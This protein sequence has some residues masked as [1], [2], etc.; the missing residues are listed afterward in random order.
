VA[1]SPDGARVAWVEAVATPEGPSGTLRTIRVTD[2][3]G[4]PVGRLTAAKDGSAHEEDEPVFSPDGGRVAFLSDAEASGQPQLYVADLKSGAVRQ[5]TH[6]AGY[7]ENP[8]WAPDGKRLAILFLEGAADARG[9][10]APS[11]RETGVIASVVHEQRLAV[12]SAEGGALSPV[13]PPDLFIYEYAWS[14]DGTR[15][16][17]TGAHGDGDNNWWTADLFLVPASGGAATRL[18]HPALQLCEPTWSP[19]GTQVAFIEGLM[20][21]FGF[22]G[23]DVFVIPATGD[24]ARNVTPGM[25]A[26]ASQLTWSAKSGLVA[27]AAMGGDS[28]FLRVDAAHAKAP[29]TLWRGGETVRRGFNISAAFASDGKSTAVIRESALEPPEVFAGDIGSWARLSKANVGARSPAAEVKSLTW[30]SDR[31]EVQGWLLL[32]PAEMTTGK[33]ALVVHVHGGPA[34]VATNTFHTDVL[35][36]LSQGYAVLLPNPR[37]SYG[38]GEAFTRANVKDFG[39]GDLRDILAGVDRVVRTGAVDGSRVGITGHS[40]GGYMTM[41][42]VTQT[43]RFKAAVASAGIANWLSYY[44]E[45]KIDQW[46]VPYFGATVYADPAVYA[47]SSPMTFITHTKTPTLVLVG[48]RDAECPAPQSYEFWHALKT[49]GVPTELVVYADEGHHFLNPA[50]VLDHTRREVAW[51]DQYLNGVPAAAAR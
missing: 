44:G 2:R 30:T 51:L 18:Y 19:D 48:E 5:L 15:F 43:N 21:D 34:G 22:N 25:H 27:A 4:S 23:G 49:L 26:S 10:L 46:M 17:A 47:R 24:R 33:P 29:V 7:L 37:G 42:A 11:I 36:L 12:V 41:F 20:S 16:G 40:Y 28:A 45:N 39:H 3:S 14:P 35:L 31:W 13:S 6:V 32:P 9:P 1:I 8:R 50:N 38:Q